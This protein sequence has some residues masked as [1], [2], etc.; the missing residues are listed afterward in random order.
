MKRMMNLMGVLALLAF[1][2]PFY[3]K[4]ID[5]PARVKVGQSW[6]TAE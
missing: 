5:G 3:A 6:M 2:F 1:S 4:A